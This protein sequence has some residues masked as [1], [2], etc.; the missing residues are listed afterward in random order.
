MKNFKSCEKF[1]TILK[2]S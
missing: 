2:T 1:H